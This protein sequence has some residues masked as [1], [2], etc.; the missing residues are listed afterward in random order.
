VEQLTAMPFFMFCYLLYKTTPII[1][2][3]SLCVGY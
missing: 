2:K 1:L 3:H